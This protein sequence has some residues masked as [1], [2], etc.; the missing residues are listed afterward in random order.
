[1]ASELQVQR[2]TASGSSRR[3]CIRPQ[4]NLKPLYKVLHFV[5]ALMSKATHGSSVNLPGFRQSCDSHIAV[6]DRLNLENAVPVCQS[7]YI[8]SPAAGT[9]VRAPGLNS[10]L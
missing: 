1:M 10:T 8:V 4:I 9:P 6:A 3:T 2:P 5:H 7:F